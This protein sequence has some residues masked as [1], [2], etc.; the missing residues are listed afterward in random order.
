MCGIK[1]SAE[2]RLPFGTHTLPAI[3]SAVVEPEYV[4][5]HEEAPLLV[6]YQLKHLHSKIESQHQNSNLKLGNSLRGRKRRT[7][8][9][10]YLAEPQLVLL[11]GEL[12]VP[13]DEHQDAAG[14]GRRGL[15]VDGADGVPAL[16]EGQLRQ[17]PADLL[18]ACDGVALEGEHGGL[19]VER[20]QRGA[21][22]VERAVV[23]FHEGPRHDVAVALDRVD[24][25]LG[26]VHCLPAGFGRC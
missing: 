26:A 1:A 12:E 14:E 7:A 23:V 9:M 24:V 3:A 2:H 15:A 17:L 22:G 18:G 16:L 20:G 11:A 5:L 25:A 10:A 6:G 21:V 19:A 4:I 13:A 8:K